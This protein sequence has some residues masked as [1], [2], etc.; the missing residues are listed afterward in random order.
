MKQRARK[1]IQTCSRGMQYF[2]HKCN[3]LL[4][5]TVPIP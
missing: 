3:E 4:S 2:F 1:D 5:T